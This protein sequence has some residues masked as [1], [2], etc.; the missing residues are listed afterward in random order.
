[1][2]DIGPGAVGKLRTAT[3]VH[4]L[5]A[6]LISHMHTDHFLDLITL[7][8]ARLNQAG[9][10]REHGARWR[11]PVYL[12]PN[13]K[14]TVEACFAA[15]PV[16]VKGTTASR[17][18]ENF[19][20]VEYD[21]A[22]RLVIGQCTVDFVGPTKH[23]QTDYGMRVRAGRGLLGYTG[24]TARCDAAVEVGR[25]ADLFLAECTLM[26]PGAHSETHTCA[27]ELVEMAM[28]ARPAR[29]LATHFLDHTASFRTELGARLERGFGRDSSVVSIGDRFEF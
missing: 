2:L 17:Y 28:A 5:D 3:D 15:L 11:L 8:V 14:A 1:L 24:D 6:V 27:A 9:E 21:P 22:Q 29:L 7:N 26:E 10:R 19:D 18:A 25:G 13:A 23:S 12:P 20:L 4:D 16:N